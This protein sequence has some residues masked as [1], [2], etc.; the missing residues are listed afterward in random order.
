MD[1]PI[2]RL[3]HPPARRSTS[4]AG[5][6]QAHLSPLVLARGTVC[7]RARQYARARSSLPF[8]LPTPSAAARALLGRVPA[9]RPVADRYE[10][11]GARAAASAVARHSTGARRGPSCLLLHHHQLIYKQFNQY[12]NLGKPATLSNYA[13]SI[14]S[15]K[16][17]GKACA[18]PVVTFVSI[19]TKCSRSQQKIVIIPPTE[20][21]V[22][23]Q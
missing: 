10:D 6:Y 12:Q 16:R 7:S 19:F 20:R 21:F 17:K 18:V 15:K 3:A 1:S 8:F 11:R 13:P 23:R 4:R 5:C 22:A 2:A 9:L 14:A